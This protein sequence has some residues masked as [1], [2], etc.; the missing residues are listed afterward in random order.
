MANRSLKTVKVTTVAQARALPEVRSAFADERH[1][2]L[3]E[4]EQGVGK[5][6]DTI[7]ELVPRQFSP[8]PIDG[9][10]I[11]LFTDAD[12]RSMQVCYTPE[13]PAKTEFRL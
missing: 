6:G 4:D 8:H 12:G 10:Q 9:D 1:R 11:L 7:I 5:K 13:G 3:T 2:M